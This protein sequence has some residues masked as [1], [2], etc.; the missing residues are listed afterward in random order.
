MSRIGAIWSERG[1]M[2]SPQT[3]AGRVRERSADRS[4]RA[5]E[6]RYGP[7]QLKP[8]TYFTIYLCSE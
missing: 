3:T 7:F 5:G 1:L 4:L 2:A 8:S 6:R